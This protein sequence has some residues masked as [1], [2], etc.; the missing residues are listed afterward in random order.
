MIAPLLLSTL[1][2]LPC[3]EP[4]PKNLILICWD[5][6]R[7]DHLGTYGYKTHGTTPHV[8]LWA[9]GATVFESASA[10]AC[11]TKPS[12]PSYLTGTPPLQHG[13]YRGSSKDA[14]GV[15]S[16]VLP[17]GS[18]TIA[19]ILQERGYRTVAFIR[20]AQLRLGQG[21]EQGFDVYDD[22]GG[23][24]REIRWKAMDFL[25]ERDPEKPFL[26]YLHMLDA[27]WPY[28]VPLE[29]ATRYADP[30]AVERFRG[31][32][33]KAFRDEVNH[34][35]RPLKTADR[36]ELIALYDGALAYL[37]VEFGRLHSFLEHEGLLEN[38]AIALISDHGEE[39][40]EHGRIGHGHGLYEGLLH[41]PWIMSVPGRAP[42]RVT[43]AVSLLDL[44][45]TLMGA[46]DVPAPP[47]EG[48]DQLADSARARPLFAEHLEPGRYERSLR[49]DQAKHI[50]RFKPRAEDLGTDSLPP[51]GMRLEVKLRLAGRDLVALEIEE[52]DDPEDSR[53]ELKGP[54]EVR[55]RR[56]SIAGIPLELGENW[57]LY[58]E[59]GQRSQAAPAFVADEMVK[60]VGFGDSSGLVVEKLKLY[61]PDAKQILELRGAF[62]GTE[63]EGRWAVGG[64]TLRVP[65]A[66]AHILAQ[67][68]DLDRVT[69]GAWFGGEVP[70]RTP[71]EILFFDLATDPGELRPTHPDQAS[72]VLPPLV[73][74]FVQRRI[75]TASDTSTLTSEE[76]EHLKAIGY[77]D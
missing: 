9:K 69:V 19:E 44:L 38:T 36:D 32:N 26:L 11:W 25:L 24:A 2:L 60:A 47:T 56:L 45:P 22:H 49:V 67:D 27:H 41:V 76:I 7:A 33:W 31:E 34:G 37:D 5:T 53:V 30:A 70:V 16:D 55:G 51:I 6:V 57:T 23:D 62:G 21:I 43:H 54:L 40:G 66:A 75:W 12:V 71:D 3:Q 46:L 73:R 52:S 20:N 48:I 35:D 42:A 29:Y 13:V 65:K 1:L 74:S 59:L 63:G 64:Q 14:A 50:E 8:D 15:I 39:F 4:K 61:G 28:P 72:K 10:S 18:V 77:G 58:G 17:A 68:R